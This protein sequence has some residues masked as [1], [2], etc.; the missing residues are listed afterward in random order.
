MA[1]P[2][3]DSYGCASGGVIAAGRY[4]LPGWIN[5]KGEWVALPNSTLN[6]SG[7]GW[8]GINPGGSG[9]YASIVNAWSGGILNTVGCYIGGVFTAGTFIVLFGGGHSDYAGN[10]LYAYGPL[11]ANSPNWHRLNDPTIPAATNTQRI[12]GY[13]VARHTYDSLV[14]LPD[15]NKMLCIGAAAYYN[16]GFSYNICDVFDFGIDPLVSNPWSTKD[17]GFPAFSGGG[18]GTI[19]IV[20]GY[21]TTTKKAWAIP[22]GNGQVLGCYDATLGSW[23]SYA[24]NNPTGPSNSKGAV[25]SS[26]NLFAFVSSGAVVVQNLASP[27]SALYSPTTTGTGPTSCAL[28]YDSINA[29]FVAWS[30]SGKTLYYLTPG[31]NPL[32]GG[33]SWTWSSVTPSSGATPGAQTANGVFGRFRFVNKGVLKGAVLMPDYNQPIYFYRAD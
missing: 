31:A 4:R 7:V 30:N 12:N 28:E 33:D 15:E 18:I 6:T 17:T 10:E 8:S 19:N 2:Q 3:G 16:L 21:N 32:S 1:T 11:E 13:P 5:P 25:D 29:R 14:Y 23:S 20:S 26:R 24:K 27:T 22:P 9:G